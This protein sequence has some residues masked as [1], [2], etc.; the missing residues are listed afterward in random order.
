MSNLLAEVPLP[1]VIE[2]LAALLYLAGA[3]VFF[4]VSSREHNALSD[5]FLAFLAS[6]AAALGLVGLGQYAEAD[7]LSLLG[8][9]AVLTGSCFMLKLPLTA[10]PKNLRNAAFFSCLVASWLILAWAMVTQVGR[11]LLPY[12]TLVYLIGVN[13]IV[14]GLTMIG[15]GLKSR[16]PWVKIKA[17]GGGVGVVTSSLAVYLANAPGTPRTLGMLLQ[18]GSPVIIL[19]AIVWGRRLQS[20][21]AEAKRI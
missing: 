9:F 19:L 15:I 6:T 2:L 16:M 8:T 18:F 10:L 3:A 4:V 5:A 17:I 1:L 11:Q 14:V 7:L 20:R 21:A 13:G 12:V